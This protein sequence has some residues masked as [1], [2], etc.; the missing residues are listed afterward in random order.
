MMTMPYRADPA[1]LSVANAL[2]A[3]IAEEM[4]AV[5][6]RTALSPNIK[7]RRDY[8]CAVFDRHG[9]LVAQAAHIPVHL[10]AMPEAVR[11][12]LPLAPF[13]PGDLI[14]LNDPYLGG[15]HLPDITM[16]SPVFA[17]QRL[18]GFVA[19]RAHH[20]DVG[21]MA[22]GS[23][24][25]A[26]EIWQEGIVIPPVRLVAAGRLQRDVLS[27]ILR[28]VR[29]PQERMG[30]LQAQIAAQKVGEARFLQLSQRLGWRRLASLMTALQDY[31]ERLTRAAIARIPDGRYSFEDFLDDDGISTEPLPIRVTVE[32]KGDHML[33]DFTGSSPQ[34]ASPINA[35]AAVTR[36]AVYYVI[37]CLLDEAVPANDGCFRPVSIC[38]PEGTIVN[39]SFPCAVSAGNVETSQRIVDVVLGALAQ[40]LPGLIPAASQGTMNNVAMGGWDP[41]RGRPFTYYETI[42]GGA[43]A[44][45]LGP[46]LDA[47]HTH[48][49]NTMN[50]PVEAL[51]MA[52]PL[53]VMEYRVRRGSG[54]EGQHRGGDGIVRTYRFLCPTIVTIISERRR[55]P[56]WGLQGG[57]PGLAGRNFLVRA[58][59]QQVV[60]PSKCQIEAQAQDSLTIETPGGGG[61][62]PL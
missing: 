62:G 48:M 51:E 46:G 37:R 40:A 25:L 3:S 55:F 2:L 17:G 59:G 61:W 16:V 27:F 10:G 12:A 7:E 45:P 38:L 49:T 35:V 39:A 58:S 23:M 13:R 8:S 50:T 28:N 21:G 6:G 41:E 14:V 56:P 4:G 11:A 9:A 36:S 24:P 34:R 18:I 33:V 15:T 52:Y 47:V 43:G 31:S 57:K 19:S 44:G 60:L 32:V 29:T 54:G 26:K 20:A 42:G 53:R 30:D 5:L 22:P 1:E